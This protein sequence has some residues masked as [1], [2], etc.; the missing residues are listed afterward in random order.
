MRVTPK[1]FLIVNI[2]LFC[3]LLFLLATPEGIIR[4][5]PHLYLAISRN[6]Y[7]TTQILLKT[8]W[9]PRTKCE[10][11]TAFRNLLYAFVSHDNADLLKMVVQSWEIPCSESDVLYAR[12]LGL[13]QC[14]EYI[15]KC[16]NKDRFRYY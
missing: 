14:A 3:I 9:Y 13:F 6:D 4:N 15:R 2:V 8:T 12:S 1:C 5:D 11:Y 10:K 7:H 16:A